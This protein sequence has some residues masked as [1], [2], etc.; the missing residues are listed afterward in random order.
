[1]V[2]T[3]YASCLVIMKPTEKSLALT[4]QI[5]ESVLPEIDWLVGHMEENEGWLNITAFLPHLAENIIT[6]KLPTWSTFYLDERQLKTLGMLVLYDI[7]ELKSVTPETAADFHEK[8]LLDALE[9]FNNVDEVELPSSEEVTE[10]FETAEKSEREQYTKQMIIG[11]YAFLTATFNYLSLM[12]FGKTLCQLVEQAQNNDIEADKALCQAVQIDRTILQLPFVQNRILKAQLGNDKYF[13]EQLAN[14]IK[15]PILSGKIRYRKLW[16]TFAILEDEGILDMPQEDLLDL[17]EGLGVYG[18]K[19]GV[20]DV[21]HLRNRLF[22]YR[23]KS[24]LGKKT[25]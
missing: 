23:K 18:Q 19:F 12:T 11:L 20:E 9:V 24:P 14:H 2:A 8:S 3:F 7:D 21:G 17:L 22:E 16:L 13:L 6:W 15:R 25:F 10:F 1:M 5:L 4:I